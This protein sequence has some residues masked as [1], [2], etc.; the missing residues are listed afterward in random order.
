MGWSDGWVSLDTETT[1]FGSEAR[2]IEIGV[3]RFE[4]GQP[5]LR[6]STLLYPPQVNWEDTK[7]QQALKV[8]GLSRNE[9]IG[10]PLFAQIYDKL[11]EVMAGQVWVAHN[12]DFDLR[13]LLQECNRCGK[14]ELMQMPQ[15]AFCTKCL[16][17]QVA[18]DL[19]NH[20]LE[21]VAQRW[22]VEQQQAHRALD[23]ATT[24]GMVLAEMYGDVLLPEDDERM[25]ALFRA[26]Q[27]AWNRKRKGGPYDHA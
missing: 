22:G 17:Y 26:S 21:T 16:A 8:N 12:V 18:P 13:M 9:L 3:T 14:T 7:V 24:C 23:D 4:Y 20:K 27:L 10:S 25:L 2:I 19:P 5:V 6:W 15:V 11:L 1:G